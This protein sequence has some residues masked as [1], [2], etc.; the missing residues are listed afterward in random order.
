MGS[1]VEDC[2]QIVLS[3][4]DMEPSELFDLVGKLTDGQRGHKPSSPTPTKSPYRS[5]LVSVASQRESAR[6]SE[7][8]DFAP[9]DSVGSERSERSERAPHIVRFP[10][11]SSSWQIGA[12]CDFAIA[13]V[14]EIEI[15]SRQPLSD[16][17]MGQC[18]GSSLAACNEAIE[19]LGQEINRLR[20]NS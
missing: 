8:L 16:W 18:I 10:Q 13:K 3:L 1:G 17:L 5:R 9:R 6:A 12:I 7:L 15:L 20:A 2:G 11:V 14:K 4:L 19:F